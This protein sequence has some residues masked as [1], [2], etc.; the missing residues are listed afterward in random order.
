MSPQN[1]VVGLAD[2]LDPELAHW[3]ERRTSPSPT[4]WSTASR[5]PPRERERSSWRDDFGI[6][7][8]WPVFCEPFKQWVLEDNFPAGRPAWKRSACSSSTDVTPYE[9][10]KIRILNGGHA[11]IAY[12]GGLLDNRR[13]SAVED[14]DLHQF[15]G[16]DILDE[17]D[18]DLLQ[19]GASG[20]EIVLQDP[21]LEGFAEDRPIVLEA[22][23]LD[24][25][26]ALAVRGGGRDA[27]HHA[28]RESHVLA[29]PRASSGSARPA[30]P[31]TA[32]AVTLPLCGMLS[33]DITV[34]GGVPSAR[35][36]PA[37]P[38]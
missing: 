28:V 21:L 8:T 5:R 15:I 9:L 3:V 20:R 26:A 7:D 12:P 30:S 1:A 10:M 14:A 36:A 22:E 32:S 34:K 19:R 35:G 29:Q 11:T 6:D 38:G 33:Q 31:T 4:P 16:T 25:E 17:G 23:A 2:L 37:R 27:V 18:A 13:V 24:Q